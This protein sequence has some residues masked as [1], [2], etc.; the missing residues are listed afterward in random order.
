LDE[1]RKWKNVNTQEGRKNYQRVRNEL[2]RATDS[3]KKEYLENICNEI[4]EFQRTGYLRY[5]YTL[6]L[7]LALD[8]DGWSM[9][10]PSRFTASKD[11]VP[12]VGE[13]GWTQGPVCTGAENL[14]HWDSIL[15]PSSL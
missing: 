11:L 10:C 6:S 7:T 15:R 8:G 3:V 14:P 13:A 1:R 12:I 2:K 9:Q 5:C 4:M